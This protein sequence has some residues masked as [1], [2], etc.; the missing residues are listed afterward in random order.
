MNTPDKIHIQNLCVNA[1]IGIY[2]EERQ[3]PQPLRLDLI[4][5]VDTHTAGET[6]NLKHTLDYDTITECAKAFVETSSFFLVEALAHHLAKALLKEFNP[7]AISI[8][9]SK[10]NASRHGSTVSVEIFRKW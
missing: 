6:D 9:I 10:P 1:I 2:P 3:I 4:L 5:F 8:T 7:D